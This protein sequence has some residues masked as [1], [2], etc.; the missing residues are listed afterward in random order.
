MVD[1][2]LLVFV[3]SFAM[4]VFA[5][6][7]GDLLRKR[8]KSSA[9]ANRD[10]SG[11]VLAGTLTLLGLI[12][13]FS[14]S[15]AI[16]RYDLRKNSEQAEANAIAVAYMRADLLPPSDVAKVHE[17]L[18]EYLDRRIAFYSTRDRN[19]LARIGDETAQTQNELWSS[20]QGALGPLPPQLEG[21]F[22]SSTNDVVVARLSTEA[23][24]SNRIPIAAWVLIAVTSVG[25]NFL[26]GYR[27]RRTDWLVFLVMPVAVSI[28]LFLISDLDSPRGGGIRVRPINLISLSQSLGNG[29][30]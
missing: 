28:S 18:K 20:I 25:C 2:P 5:A 17:L 23:V 3:V 8:S 24:W 22:V 10:D 12:I 1:F 26:I 4:L 14:F 29:V 7:V 6:W 16:S 30:K 27:A 11:V 13:G 9:E 15:M 21:L 19:K